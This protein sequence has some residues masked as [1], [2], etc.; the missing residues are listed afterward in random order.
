VV[1]IRFT[2][3]TGA[4]RRPALVVSAETFHRKLPDVIVCPISSQPHYFERPGPGDH[5]L[6]HWRSVGFKHPSTVRVS[7]I[8]AGEKRI[9]KRT[10]LAEDLSRVEEGLVRAFGFQRSPKATA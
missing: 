5:P 10:L 9:I 7:K 1:N 3:Q 6:R 4:K 8:L 2:E